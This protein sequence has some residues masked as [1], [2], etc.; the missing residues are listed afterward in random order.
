[1]IT[2][3]KF[4]RTGIQIYAQLNALRIYFVNLFLN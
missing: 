1:M 3:T 4:L 2:I